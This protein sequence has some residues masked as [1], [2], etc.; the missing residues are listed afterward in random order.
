MT[1]KATPMQQWVDKYNE[2]ETRQRGLVFG[3]AA[4]LILVLFDVLWFQGQTNRQSQLKS[5]LQSVET[6]HQDLMDANQNL[7]QQLMGTSLNKKRKQLQ[8]LQQQEQALD[9][10]LGEFAH[11]VSPRQMPKVLRDVFTYSSNLKLVELEKLPVK[12]AFNVDNQSNS[13]QVKGSVERPAQ[14]VALYRHE[15]KVSLRG[16]YLNLLKSLQQ[17]ETMQAK[18]YWQDLTYKVDNYPAADIQITIY[19]YSYNKEWIGA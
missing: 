17:L 19:T 5:Q 13:K 15:F 10:S 18:I 9:K 1:D 16:R 12:P 4:A 3:L 6:Q 7:Q 2:L 14:K 8:A 11:L